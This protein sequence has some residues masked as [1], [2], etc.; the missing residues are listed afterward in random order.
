MNYN[1]R[2][3]P[4]KTGS[5]LQPNEG[6]IQSSNLTNNKGELRPSFTSHN[7]QPRSIILIQTTRMRRMKARL[8]SNPKEKGF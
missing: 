1:N 7:S 3:F 6:S 5:S 2:D 8:T 4:T